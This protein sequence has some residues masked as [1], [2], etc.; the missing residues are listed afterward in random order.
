MWGKRFLSVVVG[1]V[2]LVPGLGS[3]SSGAERL[4]AEVPSPPGQ[5]V[6][7]TINAKQVKVLGL[8]T[9]RR[10]YN[11][12]LTLRKRP[13]AFDGGRAEAVSTPDVIVIQEMT[14]SNLEIFQKMLSQR[15]RIDYEI[16]W[17]EGSRTKFL[18]DPAGVTP[19]GEPVEWTDPCVPGPEGARTYQFARFLEQPTGLPVTIA[20]VHILPHYRDPSVEDMNCRLLNVEEIR[21]QLAQETGA[22][23]V[24]GDFNR[25]AVVMQ[26]ECDTDERSEPRDWW[27]LMT[28]ERDDAEPFVDAA[29][30]WHRAHRSAMKDQWTYG[31]RHATTNCD[32]SMRPRRSRIDYLF[33]TGA[34]V[35]E[36]SADHPGW[37]G[38]VVIP[39]TRDTPT[40]ASCVVASC[41][42]APRAR[43]PPGHRLP[44]PVWWSSRGLRW[45]RRPVTS[46][47]AVCPASPMHNWRASTERRPPT[48][49]V[50]PPMRRTIATHWPPWVRMALRDWS[51]AR[52]GPGP[53]LEA[54]ASNASSLVRVREGFQDAPRS[55]C[56]STSHSL[57]TRC[58]TPLS[59]SFRRR[60]GRRVVT[61][62]SGAGFGSSLPG[63]SSSTPGFGFGTV[64][65]SSSRF[66]RSETASGTG[67]RHS[68]RASPPRLRH[69][70]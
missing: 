44:R 1:A 67:A 43:L 62:P 66:E 31:H 15:S 41:W 51:P 70:V 45:T 65:R 52:G 36:A 27:T 2:V 59:S 53:T 34:L 37:A 40:I 47:I 57:R 64:G 9:F 8:T 17:H 3:V 11:L 7:V 6:V 18:Y 49:T 38:E 16:A 25:N 13:P 39:S 46:C 42:V 20:G 14:F 54:R 56:G 33:V 29:R 35:A 22:V 23:V 69:H 58:R 19:G 12:T 50:Q 68:D 63:R 28:S 10:L 55:S 4:P 26:R 24:A 5:V 61:G 48:P 32:G 21:N 60:G 30:T